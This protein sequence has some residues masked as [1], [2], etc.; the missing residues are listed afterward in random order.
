MIAARNGHLPVVEYLVERGADL[1]TKDNVSN[2]I[3]EMKPHMRHYVSEGMG[4]VD[5]CCIQW[6]FNSG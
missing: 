1:K 3:I 5:M 6:S 4:A 2:M